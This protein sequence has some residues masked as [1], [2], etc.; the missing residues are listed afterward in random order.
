[1]PN[2]DLDAAHTE[3]FLATEEGQEWQDFVETANK[4]LEFDTETVTVPAAFLRR[5]IADI[6]VDP[7][8]FP[9]LAEAWER[10]K[11]GK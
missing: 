5:V 2:K 3:R 11:G 6:A 1:M 10:A 8:M 7:L 9:A 4:A